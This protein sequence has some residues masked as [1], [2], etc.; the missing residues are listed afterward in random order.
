[1]NELE[2]EIAEISP[3]R[4]RERGSDSGSG[5]RSQRNCPEIGF[6][7]TFPSR[8]PPDEPLSDF[9]P[10][11]S[12]L[13]GVKSYFRADG[14]YTRRNFTPGAFRAKLEFLVF[15]PSKTKFLPSFSS[16]DVSPLPSDD[17]VANGL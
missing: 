8:F 1:M 15:S 10:R 3:E 17:E 2:Q 16:A 9:A 6:R 11:I 4:E 5:A 14:P 13:I 12:M 7:R